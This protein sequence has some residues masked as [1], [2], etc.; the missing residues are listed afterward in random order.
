VGDGER[1][2]D[3][4]EMGRLDIEYHLIE[5]QLLTESCSCAELDRFLDVFT[6][7]GFLIPIQVRP[8]FE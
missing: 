1:A 4:L 8:R 2:G 6:S 7:I 5:W 3:S